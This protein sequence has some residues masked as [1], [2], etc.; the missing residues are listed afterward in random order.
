[1][2]IYILSG[3]VRL[4]IFFT[5]ISIQILGCIKVVKQKQ[6]K[7]HACMKVKCE[8]FDEDLLSK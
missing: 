2:P 8:N 7:L 4:F 1:M 5:E 3:C 6:K